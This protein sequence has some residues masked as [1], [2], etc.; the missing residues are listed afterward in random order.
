MNLFSHMFNR[1][2]DRP[3][4][5]AELDQADADAKKARRE[6]TFRNVRN[7]PTGFVIGSVEPSGKTRRRKARDKKAFERKVNKVNRRAYMDKRADTATLRGHLVILGVVE[8]ASTTPPFSDA[9]RMTSAD[10]VVRKYGLRGD[11]GELVLH[12]ALLPEALEAARADLLDRY[13]VKA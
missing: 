9:R 11:D 1:D 6:H 10:W 7:G 4:T 8:C 12:D 5:E 2:E 13:G 3:L